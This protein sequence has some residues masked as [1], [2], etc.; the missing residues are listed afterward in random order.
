MHILRKTYLAALLLVALVAVSC[1]ST[2]SQEE[3]AHTE[4][5]LL[6]TIDRNLELAVAQYKVLRDN[7]PADRFP[8]TYYPD[9]NEYEFSGSEW[10]VSGFYPGTLLM[11]YQET[12][13]TAMLAEAK[14]IM[15]VLEKE[16]NNTRTHDLGFM[17]YDSFGELYEMEP[18]EQTKQILLQSAESLA[19]RYEPTVGAIKSWDSKE[20]DYLVI[21]DN[22]MN[23]ELLYWASRV[24]GDPKYADIATTHANTT[25]ANHFRPDYSTFHVLNYNK[26]TGDVQEKK[27][28]Q[29]YADDSA[30]SRGQAWGLYGYTATYRDTDDKKYLEQAR[31][32][33]DYILSQPNLPADKI[34]YWDYDA[35]DIPDAPRDASA[36]AIMA[37]AL[38]ELSAYVDGDEAKRY[39]STAE[40]ILR[41]LS[42]DEYLAKPGTNGGFLLEHSVG[43]LPAGT[44]VDVPL[45][46]ADFYFVEA[47]QRYKELKK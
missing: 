33:A 24:T 25:M 34:P 23:L 40:T 20:G 39:V 10:W 1:S 19:S 36:A 38:L 9:R 26:T 27:T 45:T 42:G 12:G 47:M 41:T 32:I 17:M 15:K 46:Y 7:L 21:I 11:L 35:P 5:G 18:D 44:E 13:D 2:R 29:G 16:K 8:K 4:A 22:M 31:R 28:A 6:D 14:R 30:W 43:H 37:S 3:P